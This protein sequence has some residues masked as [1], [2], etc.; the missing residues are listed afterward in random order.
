MLIY[1]C[2][3][4]SGWIRPWLWQTAMAM[5][6]TILVIYGEDLNGL[7]RKTFRKQPFIVRL[8]IFTL[9]CAFGYG[10]LAVFAAKG[11]ALAF[12]S[13]DNVWLAPAVLLS[14]VGVGLLAQ[15]RRQI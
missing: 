8:G 6:A 4:V 10:A 9:L 14:F 2:E 11:L 7:A 3:T 5:V 15:G 13:L 1:C 12:G